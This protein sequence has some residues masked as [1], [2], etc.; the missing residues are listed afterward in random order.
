MLARQ[1]GLGSSRG[2]RGS[3]HLYNE[4]HYNALMTDWG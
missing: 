3:R 2:A 4:L 1:A